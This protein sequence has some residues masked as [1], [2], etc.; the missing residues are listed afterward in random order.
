[1][2]QVNNYFIYNAINEKYKKKFP[3]DA[4]NVMGTTPKA[5]TQDIIQEGKEA[6]MEVHQDAEFF[7]TGIPEFIGI[8]SVVSTIKN[9]IYMYFLYRSYYY[10]SFQNLVYQLKV[11]F[12]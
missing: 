12:S 9:I 6:S 8:A 10:F 5:T 3:D 11:L 7:N 1:M 2:Y 4:I